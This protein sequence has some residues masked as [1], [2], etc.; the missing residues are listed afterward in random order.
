MSFLFPQLK[1]LPLEPCEDGG[2]AYFGGAFK[3]WDQE[4]DKDHY[5]SRQIFDHTSRF[6]NS[7]QAIATPPYH[8]H[9][10]QHETFDVISGTMH[11]LLDG[12]EGVLKPGEKVQIAPGRPHTFWCDGKDGEDMEVLITVRGGPNPGFDGSF[13]RN[14]YGFL[15][16]NALQGRTPNFFHAMAYMYDSDV[17]IAD[18]PLGAGHLANYVAGLGIGKYVAGYKTKHDIYEATL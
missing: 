8:W 12:K 10:Y 5:T 15:H 13:V 18:I 3:T 7:R 1:M 16:S 11:Y 2:L 9:I 6:T 4:W 14:F 17:I